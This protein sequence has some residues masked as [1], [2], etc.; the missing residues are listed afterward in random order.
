MK[1][2][3][4]FS[5]KDA[6]ALW[7]VA[8]LIGMLFPSMLFSQSKVLSLDTVLKKIERNH[9]LLKS[10]KQKSEAFQT[11]ASGA[12]S[13]MAPEVGGGFWMTPYPGEKVDPMNKGQ[14]MLSVQQKFT[15]PAK[16]NATQKY[17]SSQSGI[18]EANERI[19]FNELRAEARL[20]YAQRVALERKTTTLKESEENAL[21][22]LKIA[23]LRYSLN[24][25][26]LGTIYKTEARIGEI[27]NQLVMNETQIQQKT[28]S[29]NRLMNV[30]NSHSFAVDTSFFIIGDDLVIDATASD[31]SVIQKIDKT[32]ESLK[33]NQQTEL[34]QSKPDFS[35]SFSHMIPLGTMP[36]QFMLQ[37]MVSIPIAPWSSGSY[38]ANSRGIE[39]EIESMKHEKESVQNE[40]QQ[41][42]SNTA[43]EITST[44]KQLESYEKKI[45]PML[46]KNYDLTFQ[47][48]EE[49]KE[50]LSEVINAWEALLTTQLQ[51]IDLQ[52]KLNENQIN[53]E[54]LL[55]K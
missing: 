26:K 34:A 8:I 43:V 27:Q 44:Q 6:K 28:I 24:Q 21:L 19:V 33:F 42:L 1:A 40:L 9:P 51:F 22:A 49:N 54:K 47:A 31:Q 39:K 53:Y 15:N 36:N 48:Y 50:E 20:N 32:I 13:Q 2:L 35:L 16:L 30:P 7:A 38:K 37:G 55:D 29:L 46:K 23:K 14:F 3:I 11:Y 52:L 25:E 41:E 10:F 12:K 4:D 45:L 17:L 18:E 5:S